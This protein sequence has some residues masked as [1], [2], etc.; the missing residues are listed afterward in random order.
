MTFI[1][2]IDP[3]KFG[4]LAAI[5]PLGGIEIFDCPLL[6]TQVNKKRKDVLNFAELC[7]LLKP[8]ARVAVAAIEDVNS[9]GMG[10]QSAFRFG[11]NVGAWSAACAAFDIP[12]VK[13]R[14]QQWKHDLELDSDKDRARE[15]AKLLFPSSKP[16]LTR[17]KD[18]DRAE[19]LLIAYWFQNYGQCTTTK[20]QLK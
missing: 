19:A 9:F 17:K 6:Q 10:R 2:G 7:A 11:V 13:V 16:Y 4:A 12:L 1:L 20:S 14:P 3:G 8:Y 5:C 18:H 15:Y